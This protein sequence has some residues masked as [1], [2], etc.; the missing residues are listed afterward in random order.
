MLIL[1][2]FAWGIAAGVPVVVMAAM[3]VAIYQPVI[4]AVGLGAVA[5]L[6]RTRR[7]P[8]THEGA[9]LQAV[10]SELRSGSAVRTALADAADRVP[11]L[12]LA[13]AGRLGRAGRPLDEVAA[14]VEA[15]LPRHGPLTAAAVRIAGQTGGRVAETFDELAL[16]AGE[17]MELRGETRA[18][19]AQARLSAWIVG[20]IPVGYLAY[21]VASGKLSAL[22]D[23]GTIGVAVLGV[24]GALLV[25]GV[26]AVAT[27]VGRTQR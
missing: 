22:V 7:R 13:Q 26:I 4:A 25:A 18:A 2:G 6:E 21:S 1:L 15:A 16:I 10:A 19:T 17:D 14:A 5:V 3:A 12:P 9:F 23:T 27:I 8:D 11:A 24:G 20:G